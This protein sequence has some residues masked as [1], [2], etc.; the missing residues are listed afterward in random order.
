MFDAFTSNTRS[1][2]RNLVS[3]LNHSHLEQ[4]RLRLLPPF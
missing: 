2:L 4:R 1:K 3:H